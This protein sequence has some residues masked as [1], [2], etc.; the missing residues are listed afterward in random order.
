[1][2][3]STP[4]GIALVVIGLF[5]AIKAAKTVVKVTMLL[6]IAAGVYL[7]LQGESLASLNP[8]S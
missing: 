2:E 8:F 1:M 4:L 5:V 3:I 6:V 7:A